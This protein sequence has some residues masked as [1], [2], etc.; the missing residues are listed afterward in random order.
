MPHIASSVKDEAAI[1]LIG[2]WIRQLPNLDP[3]RAVD[4]GAEGIPN[5]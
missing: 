4:I 1:K 2:D 5:Q 3:K